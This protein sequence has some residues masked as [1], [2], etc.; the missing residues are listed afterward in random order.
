MFDTA[1]SF[2]VMVVMLN[3]DAMENGYLGCI[4]EKMSQI[5]FTK[6]KSRI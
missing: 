5:M 2:F 4:F 1:V 3:I 6:L